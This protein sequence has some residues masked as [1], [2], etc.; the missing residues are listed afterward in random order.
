MMFNILF[1]EVR[2]VNI[3]GNKWIFKN[4]SNKLDEK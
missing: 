4:K 1:L 2:G 3:R